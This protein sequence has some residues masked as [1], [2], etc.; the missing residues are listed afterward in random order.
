MRAQQRKQRDTLR[1]ER[2]KYEVTLTMKE[3]SDEIKELINIMPPVTERCQ[4]AVEK[5]S[6]PGIKLQGI[7]KLST[8]SA[9]AVKQNK[10]GNFAPSIGVKPL[11]EIKTHEPNYGIVI[12]GIPIDELDL[13]E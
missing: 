4:H 3:T 8:A 7:K 6:I 11:K 13:D 2:A 1:Q 9:Y 12:H 5:A 10:Q